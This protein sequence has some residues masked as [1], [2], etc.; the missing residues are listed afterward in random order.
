MLSLNILNFYHQIPWA[1]GL[2]WELHWQW[3]WR[4]GNGDSH[5]N[6]HLVTIL[7]SS[8]VCPVS[9]LHDRSKFFCFGPSKNSTRWSWLKEM[10]WWQSGFMESLNRTTYLKGTYF[11]HFANLQCA[12]S[13]REREPPGSFILSYL[14]NLQRARSQGEG[15]RLGLPPLLWPAWERWEV[16]IGHWVLLR[17]AIPFIFHPKKF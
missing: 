2:L 3:L 10:I 5:S 4:L 1:G 11:V 9:H 8:Q 13:K 17:V 14:T 16:G 7:P 12:R 6:P 15:S